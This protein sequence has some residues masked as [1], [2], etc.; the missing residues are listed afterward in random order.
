[1][2]LKRII[3]FLKRLQLASNCFSVKT[4]TVKNNDRVK[5]GENTSQF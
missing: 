4:M 3:P 5:S 2:I 1:M